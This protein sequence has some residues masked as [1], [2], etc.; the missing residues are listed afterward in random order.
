LGIAALSQRIEEVIS[1][2][3]GTMTQT[4]MAAGSHASSVLIRAGPL[5]WVNSPQFPLSFSGTPELLWPCPTVGF[6]LQTLVIVNLI[7]SSTSTLL[8]DGNC[9]CQAIEI[10]FRR[11]FETK[12]FFLPYP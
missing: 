10:C 8:S 5:S 12:P 7:N 6:S 9:Y 1:A 3:G 2:A 11:I 4:F